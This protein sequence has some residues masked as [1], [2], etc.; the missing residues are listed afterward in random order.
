MVISQVS[1][2]LNR[3]VEILARGLV[4][5]FCR[6][7]FARQRTHW[8]PARIRDEAIV[9]AITVSALRLMLMMRG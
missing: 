1:I 6:F 5:G 4:L 2:V 3:T 7:E 9:T 8:K